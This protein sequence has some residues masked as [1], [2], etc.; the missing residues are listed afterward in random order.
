M[1]ERLVDRIPFSKIAAVLATVFGVSL[2]LCGVTFV[3]S[4]GGN[5]GSGFF[6]GL[7]M[8]ELAAMALS[9]AGLALTLVVYVT[10]LIFGS[11][12]EKVSQPQKLFDDRDDTKIDKNE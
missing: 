8:L 1:S 12:S 3:L 6:E 4:S 11:F 10:L 9:A 5:R 7:G 2:G